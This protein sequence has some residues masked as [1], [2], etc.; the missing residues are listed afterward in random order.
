LIEL[1]EHDG[2]VERSSASVDVFLSRVGSGRSGMAGLVTSVVPSTLIGPNGTFDIKGV[3]PGT[4]YAIA[5]ASNLEDRQFTGR[6]RLD[7]GLTDISNIGI[8]LRAGIDLRGRV[9]VEGSAPSGFDLSSLRVYLVSDQSTPNGKFLWRS[10]DLASLTSKVIVEGSHQDPDSAG[11]VAKDGSFSIS[12]VGAMQY[13]VAVSG[14]PSNAYLQSGRI[15]AEDALN[16]PFSI[17]APTTLQLVIGFSPGRI[18]GTVVDAKGA[19]AAGAQVV[20]VPD[21]ARRG[22][23]DAYFKVV[24]TQDGEFTLN[25]IPP[26]GYKLFAWDDVPAGAYQYP[27]FLRDFE[28]RGVSVNVGPD[29]LTNANLRVIT[30]QD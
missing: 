24:S 3:A 8:S 17:D 29:T 25:N 19:P 4:Y 7:V 9:V 10:Y 26:G 28:N 6:T 20:L 13:R 15:G 27:D 5:T 22:R 16:A 1:S 12:D 2:K 30:T 11:K 23:S 14:L 21:E 18:S